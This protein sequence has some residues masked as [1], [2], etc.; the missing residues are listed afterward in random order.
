MVRARLGR[1][2]PNCDSENFAAV[3]R[4]LPVRKLLVII[5]I[6]P[7]IARIPPATMDG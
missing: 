3:T 2:E 7:I 5:K 6:P 4:K 1:S